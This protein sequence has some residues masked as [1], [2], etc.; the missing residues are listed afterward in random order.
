MIIRLENVTLRRGPICLLENCNFQVQKG[1]HIGLIG[2]NGV[3]KTSLLG[4]LS[5]TLELDSGELTIS[6][7]LRIAHMEQEMQGSGKNAVEFVLD[8]DGHLRQLQA[9]LASAE[10]SGDETSIAAIHEELENAGAYDA[11]SRAE[12]IL[13]GLGFNETE[14]DL[15]YSNFSGGWR[16]RLNL[17]RVLFCPA[18]LLLLDEPTNHLD[19]D[20]TIWLEDWL[21]KYRGAILLISHDR[22]FLDKTVKQVARIEDRQLKTFRGNYSAYEQQRSEQLSQQQALFEKQQRRKKEIEAFVTRFRAK[23]TKARQAQSRLKELDRMEHIAAANINSPFTFKINTEGKLSD[24][25]IKLRDVVVGYDSRRILENVQ[26]SI[27]PGDRIGILGRNGA[28]KT[29]LLKSLAGEI[30]LLAGEK[31]EGLHLA[32]AYFAQ[33]QVEEL[34]LDASPFTHLLRKRKT[35]TDQEIRD[36]LGGFNFRGE[37]VDESVGIFSGGEKARL[38]L[39][40]IAWKKPNLLFLDE[41]TNHLDMEM[42]QSL[43]FALQE[44][45]GALVMIS[46][47]R[48]LL[49]SCVNEFW[50][51][52]DGKMSSYEG[53]LEEYQRTLL[54]VTRPVTTANRARNSKKKRQEQAEARKKLSPLKKKLALLENEIKT[55]RAELAGIEKEL[56]SPGIY[57]AGRKAELQQMLIEQGRLQVEVEEKELAWFRAQEELDRL[58]LE[59]EENTDEKQL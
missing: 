31:T 11:N 22:H 48:H 9:G 47:D 41:P 35:A 52:E 44:Y 38:A 37:R 24:P 18:D 27:S 25:L 13:A 14:L 29:T 1:E 59:A 30:E 45:Q 19:L 34:D 4:L 21:N 23:A 33:H 32:S 58:A 12:S 43:I 6:R 51:V 39:A 36:F 49:S 20:A 26:L 54:Q 50:L 28:G 15:P 55:V 8:G 7:G 17:A 42:R 10:Q 56:A 3:G 5:R 2:A 46:H 53:S 16:I 40:I 57:D